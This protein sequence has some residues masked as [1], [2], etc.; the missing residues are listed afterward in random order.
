MRAPNQRSHVA[1]GGVKQFHG[2]R[3]TPKMYVKS[4]ALPVTTRSLL[5]WRKT[6]PAPKL[7]LG[8]Q[9]P[10]RRHH[11]DGRPPL[12]VRAHFKPHLWVWDYFQLTGIPWF[13][14][15]ESTRE[16]WVRSANLLPVRVMP[17]LMAASCDRA[18]P[19]GRF[20][21]NQATRMPTT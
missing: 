1:L 14:G 15:I 12:P 5:D 21:R 3:L 13:T 11:A 18:P 9:C 16:F 20:E 8:G 6:T 19:P 2:Q 10:G 17:I 7:R 4:E